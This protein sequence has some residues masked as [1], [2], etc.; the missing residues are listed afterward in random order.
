[1]LST[2]EELAVS[3]STLTGTKSVRKSE[4]LSKCEL[5]SDFKNNV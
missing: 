5:L 2:S 3:L 1:M 4:Q